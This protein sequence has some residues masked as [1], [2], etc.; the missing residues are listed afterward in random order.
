MPPIL[1][2]KLMEV[3]ATNSDAAQRFTIMILSRRGKAAIEE[4]LES[5]ISSYR[6]MSPP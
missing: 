4:A 3:N 2:R 5:K 6:L 1:V